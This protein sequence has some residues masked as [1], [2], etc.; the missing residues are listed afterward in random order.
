MAGISPRIPHLATVS[1]S[2]PPSPPPSELST[3]AAAGQSVT[4]SLRP[5]GHKRHSS[6]L[7]GL[8]RHFGVDPQSLRKLHGGDDALAEVTE[9]AICIARMSALQAAVTD[10]GTAAYDAQEYLA[11]NRQPDEKIYAHDKKNIPRLTEYLNANIPGLSLHPTAFDTPAE[12]AAHIKNTGN[13]PRHARALIRMGENSAHHAVVD[14]MIK[15]R[16]PGEDNNQ[17][18][19]ICTDS[20]QITSTAVALG[21]GRLGREIKSTLPHAVASYA[22]TDAQRSPKDC[23]LFSLLYATKLNL[24]RHLFRELHAKQL[25][26]EPID[27]GKRPADISSE[28]KNIYIITDGKHFLPADF[29]EEAHSPKVLDRYFAARPDQKETL[30]GKNAMENLEKNLL[31]TPRDGKI[32]STIIEVERIDLMTNAS[33][34]NASQLDILKNS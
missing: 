8:E 21:I 3:P 2:P 7:A 16:R 30:A 15:E 12:F 11:A 27:D 5:R 23:I 28:D 34:H 31:T 10:L 17:V 18:S 32:Y 14:Y 33:Q 26:G 9:E 1:K 22:L 6:T 20:G 4:D 24:H 19:V 29:W 13:E 25:A